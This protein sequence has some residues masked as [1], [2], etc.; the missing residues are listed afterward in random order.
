MKAFFNKLLK[1]LSKLGRAMLIPVAAMP[2]AGMTKLLFGPTM[3][4][5][6]FVM[7]AGSVV[8]S[9]I[10][11]LFAM[12]SSVAFS[13]GKN[14]V[15]SMVASVLSL[16]ILRSCL[17]DLNPDVKMGI[18]AGIVV[19]CLSAVVYNKS[20]H[21][22]TP[23]IVDFF[24]GEK[25]VITLMPMITVIL[26][27]GLAVV[28]PPIQNALD[29]FATT[30][31]NLGALGV[32]IFGFLNRLLIPVG[33]HHVLN[34]Y[35]YYDLGNYVDPSGEVIM[36]EI[37]RFV[38][39]DPTAGTFLVGF[40]VVMIFGLPG[41]ALAIARAAKKEKRAEAEGLMA[42]TAVTSVFTGITEPLEFSFMFVSPLLYFVHA[43]FTG[44]AGAT[45]YILGCRI[46][47]A[48]GARVP[49]LLLAWPSADNPWLIIPIGI[50]FF[51]LY[52]VTFSYLIRKKDMKT[53]GREDDMI[54][55]LEVTEEEK[56]FKLSTSNYAY[57]AKKLLQCV[58]GK[59]N[60][61][62]SAHCISRLRLEVHD[63]SLV[64]VERIK[65]T[66]VRGV[67]E[68]S[69]TSYQIVIGNDVGRVA[70]EFDALL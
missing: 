55:S 28:W 18:F 29:I 52:F 43:L 42:S 10:D 57:L 6:P 34:S 67:I 19:G 48:S 66:G 22:K 53:P 17:A 32:F 26:S 38:A 30:L 63:G 46:G 39:G 44:L 14:K 58:G 51:I 8:I 2:I 70:E 68:V 65:Q 24:T 49:D 5:I 36:G 27:L 40:Y 56:S 45:C 9:N 11:L 54:D 7:N 33:L 16:L 23:K 37:T 59:E 15:H 12:G 61:E 13:E 41:A 35:I 4:N 69:P 62:Q 64:D 1:Q 50:V 25:F 47:F 3:L 31:G 60:V 21:W 20:R